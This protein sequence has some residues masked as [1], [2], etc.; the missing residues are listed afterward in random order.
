MRAKTYFG[1]TYK[2]D[3]FLIHQLGRIEDIEGDISVMYK[4][5]EIIIDKDIFIEFVLENRKIKQNTNI[6]DLFELIG[7]KMF[8]NLDKNLMD[9]ISRINY[10]KTYDDNNLLSIYINDKISV[11]EMVTMMDFAQE[12]ANKNGYEDYIYLDFLW[13]K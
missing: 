13:D 5:K 2:S 1:N 6:K 4:D 12:V 8:D 11:K 9:R 3:N 7:K 10:T